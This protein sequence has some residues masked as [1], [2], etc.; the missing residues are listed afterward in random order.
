ML[1][2]IE[3][4]FS[5]GFYLDPPETSLS[6]PW[7]MTWNWGGGGFLGLACWKDTHI[8]SRSYSIRGRCRLVLSRRGSKISSPLLL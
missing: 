8:R 5:P 2:N 7:L 6:V 1:S 4:T 3:V